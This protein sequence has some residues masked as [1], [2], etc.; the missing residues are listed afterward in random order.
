MLDVVGMALVGIIGYTAKNIRELNESIKIV[1]LRVDI[2][3]KS[4]DDHESRLRYIEKP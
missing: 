1:I 3:Q 2:H 4:I